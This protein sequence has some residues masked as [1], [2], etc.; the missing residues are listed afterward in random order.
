MAIYD[1]ALLFVFLFFFPETMRPQSSSANLARESN[2]AFRQLTK[3]EIS[4]IYFVEP[5]KIFKLLKCPAVLLVTLVV[6]FQYMVVVRI[7]LMSL[8]TFLQYIV[9]LSLTYGFQRS[10]YFFRPSIVG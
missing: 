8:L 7:P 9:T 4:K 1:G 2:G 5:L 3:W 10:P 6:G